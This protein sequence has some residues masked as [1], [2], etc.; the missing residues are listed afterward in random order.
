M[1]KD[2]LKVSIRQHAIYLPAIEGTEKREA[3]TSTTVTLVAQ[4]RKVGYSLSVVA[5]CQSVVSGTTGGDSPGDERSI[6]CVTQ[7]GSIG[8]RLG[9]TYRRNTFGSLD[10]MAC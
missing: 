1:K 7:L 4:L 8:E 9:Y 10:Y 3:L 6:G 2:L 5:C